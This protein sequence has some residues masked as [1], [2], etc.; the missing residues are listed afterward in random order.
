MDTTLKC[1]EKG[2]YMLKKTI[3]ATV[4]CVL[5]LSG[6][7]YAAKIGL[8]ITATG[9]Y[10]EFVPALIDSARSYFLNDHEVTYFVFTDGVL[11][12][13]S[14]LVVIYQERMGWPYDTLKRYHVY[15]TNQD[16]LMGQDYLF[17]TDADMLFV[18]YVGNE[19]L[20]KRVATIHPGFAVHHTNEWLTVCKLYNRS[21]KYSMSLNP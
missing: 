17:A 7:A 15:M 4:L 12:E 3:L 5:F 2:K 21:L 14:D 6:Q 20:G 9:R 18:D 19:V 8:L 1:D 13:A 16:F 10:I 11:P